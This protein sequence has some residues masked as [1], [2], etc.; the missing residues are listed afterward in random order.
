MKLTSSTTRSAGFPVC[1][2]SSAF[3]KIGCYEVMCKRRGN[4][5]KDSEKLC[6]SNML[7]FRKMTAQNSSTGFLL[8]L[9]LFE[10]HDFHVHV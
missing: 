9:L 3:L 4:W 1:P 10:P 6:T 2:A 8:V 5:L 7:C